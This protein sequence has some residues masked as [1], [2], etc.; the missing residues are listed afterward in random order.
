MVKTF[1]MMSF[2]K[3][4]SL[5]GSILISTILMM[6]A[7]NNKSSVKEQTAGIRLE[8]LDTEAIAGDDFYQFATGGWQNLNPL[9]GEYARFGSFDKLGE[10]NREQLK[11]LIEEIA[12]NPAKP[13]TISRRLPTCLMWL[14][15]ACYSI[16]PVWRP[17]RKTFRKLP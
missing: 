12:A 7:C 16:Q 8:N 6:S 14:W 17:F 10:Q 3:S 5:A 11:G 1:Q 13:G 2:F 15:T 9:T 4:A